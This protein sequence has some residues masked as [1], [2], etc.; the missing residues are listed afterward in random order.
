MLRLVAG[1]SNKE[2]AARLVI[3]RKTA[4]NHVEHIYAKIDVSNRAAAACSRCGT[5]CSAIWSPRAPQ[6]AEPRAGSLPPMIERAPFG[7]TG[8]DVE[9][10]DLRRRGARQRLQARRR[11]SARAAARARHQPH[12]RRRQLRRRRAADRAVAAPAP[13]EFFVATKTGE[14][15]YARRAR[16]DPPLARPPRRRPGRLDPAAQPRRRDRV[17]DRARRRRRARGGD[18]GARRGPRALH[19]RDRPRPVGAEM[20]R[21][22]LERFAFDS[23]L[24]PVQLR[25]DAGPALRGDVRG[26]RRA[27]AR[28]RNVALQTIKSLVARAAGTGARA[29]AAHLVRAAARAGRHRPGRALGARPAE[30]FLLT[31]GD[32]DVL[33]ALLD[34]AERFER[35]PPTRRWPQLVEQRLSTLFA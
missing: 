12:R 27:C 31:T 29:T 19:R 7:A 5:A 20:H 4:G 30:A 24:L 33:P 13:G 28:E 35:P 9:P 32:V 26:A 10:R 23:V 25:A 18:R 16:G 8:H 3:S 6:R 2:I 22:S 11:P 17:G 15:T 14:R 1:L 21:R 34:A